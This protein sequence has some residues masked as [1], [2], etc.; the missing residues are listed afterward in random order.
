MTSLA[1]ARPD[2]SPGIIGGRFA[3]K[4]RLGDDE[5]GPADRRP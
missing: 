5:H 3:L 1:L 4:R 2:V